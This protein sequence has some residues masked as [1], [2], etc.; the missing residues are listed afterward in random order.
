MFNDVDFGLS[1]IANY[2]RW[3]PLTDGVDPVQ[4]QSL[5]NELK[6]RFGVTVE[7]VNIARS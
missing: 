6:G 1:N 4:Y 2:I 5:L 3:E 7:Q